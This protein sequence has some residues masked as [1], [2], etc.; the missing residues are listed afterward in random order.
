MGN[1]LAV[2]VHAAN[3]HDTKKILYRYPNIQACC[4]DAGYCGTFKHTF[5][6]FYNIRIDISKQIRP[7]FE[8]LP[9]RWRVER[10]LARMGN[11]SAFETIVILLAQVLRV[12]APVSR[13]GNSIFLLKCPNKVFTVG[14]SY[15]LADAYNAQ[16]GIFQQFFRLP[17]TESLVQL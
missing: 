9:K 7:K 16:R 4:A 12:V 13:R 3:I 10:T 2:Y 14:I 17:E 15:C 5:E 11:S 1:L 6:E 8:I